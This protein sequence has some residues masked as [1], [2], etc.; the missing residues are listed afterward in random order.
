MCV[1]GAFLK[2]FASVNL[3]HYSYLCHIGKLSNIV[4]V[5]RLRVLPSLCFAKFLLL[6]KFCHRRLRSSQ[7]SGAVTSGT[8]A[9]VYLYTLC[10]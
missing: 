3:A 7:P 1:T 10:V 4:A 8:C 9:S 2:T 5:S 6:P